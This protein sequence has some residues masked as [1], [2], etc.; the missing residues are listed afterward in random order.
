MTE[1]T[2]SFAPDWVSPPGETILD[3][4]TERDWTQAQ[5]AQRLGYTTKHVSLLMNG[6]API[7]EET[8]LKLEKV[9]GSTANFWLQREAQYRAHLAHQEEKA[10]LHSWTPWLEQLPV[11]DLMQQNVIPTYRLDGKNKP[12]IVK[13]LLHFF[14]VASPEEW[15][16]YYGQMEV[17]FRRTRQNQSDVGAIS[18]WL[19]LGEIEAERRDCPKYDKSRFLRAIQEI[20]KLTI[21]SPEEFVPKIV[22]LCHEAGVVCVFVPAISRANVSGVTRWFNPHKALIQLSL[23]GKSNDRFWF[24]FFHEAAHILLHDKKAIFLDEWNGSRGEVS[25]Q[26]KEADEWARDFLIPSQYES[27]LPGLKARGKVKDFADEIG[28]HPGI[29]VGRLQHELIIQQNWMNDLKDNLEAG[30][31][32]FH[33]IAGVLSEG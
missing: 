1:A 19:R 10:R 4:L 33:T 9:L 12:H 24:T 17:A 32:S 15:E 2:L 6:K 11:R 16:K 14:G 27:E 29:V 13:D 5:L 31:D 21:L 3:L 18:A 20:R 8:A 23:Y 25:R 26:E 28:I 7:T 30:L 22:H